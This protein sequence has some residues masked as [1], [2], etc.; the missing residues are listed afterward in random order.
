MQSVSVSSMFDGAKRPI[1]TSDPEQIEVLRKCLKKALQNT[2]HADRDLREAP[3]SYRITFT[4]KNGETET[5]DYKTY[6]TDGRRHDNPFGN[7]YDL[8]KESETT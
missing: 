4:Y 7:F 1:V 6:P 8:F 5:R 2:M 3:H